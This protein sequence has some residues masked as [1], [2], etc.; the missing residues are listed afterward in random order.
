MP[1]TD[2]QLIERFNTRRP[3]TGVLFKSQILEVRAD[4]GFVQ[5]GR[6]HV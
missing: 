3:P 2:A 6:A 1:L 5:I 4:E